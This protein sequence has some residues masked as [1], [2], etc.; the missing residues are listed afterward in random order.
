MVRFEKCRV[1]QEGEKEENDFKGF[2]KWAVLSPHPGNHGKGV[3][4]SV[5]VM[6]GGTFYF[7]LEK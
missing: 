6:G 2:P 3:I 5:V 7:S 1:G 4:T